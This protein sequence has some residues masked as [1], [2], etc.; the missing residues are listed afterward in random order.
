LSPAFQALL[1]AFLLPLGQQGGS[2]SAQELAHMAWAFA[3][4][5]VADEPRLQAIAAAARRK[6]PEF[7]AGQLS[8][9]AWAWAQL[10][11]ADVPLLA[12]IAAAAIPP[13]SSGGMHPHDVACTAWA[14]AKLGVRHAPLRDAISSSARRRLPELAPP[15]LACTAWALAALFV[16]DIPLLASISAQA[17]RSISECDPPSLANMSWA[18]A[19]LLFLALPGVPQ[20]AHSVLWGALK[21]GGIMSKDVFHGIAA[22]APRQMCC[23]A[24][25][26]LQHRVVFLQAWRRGPA[27]FC[28]YISSVPTEHHAISRLGA[29]QHGVVVCPSADSRS[30]AS[31]CYRRC[32][33]TAATAVQLRGGCQHRMVVRKAGVAAPAAV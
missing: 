5:A 32:F 3:K 31:G 10:L 26:A 17:L 18:F 12:S 4:L 1:D 30:P 20:G 22:A 29:G 8:S 13:I 23:F 27:F 25:Q 6:L 21:R 2:A 7:E 24:P 28:G 15:A 11:R 14:F 33:A 9:T 19:T 16:A